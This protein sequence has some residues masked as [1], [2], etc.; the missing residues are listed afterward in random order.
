MNKLFAKL[1]VAVAVVSL[2]AVP[3][4]PSTV[5]A[6]GKPCDGGNNQLTLLPPW[7]KGLV[8]NDHGTPQ[9][10]TTENGL[11]DFIFRIILN[12]TEAMLYIVGY[13][14]LGMIIWGGFKYMLFGDN[15]GGV[16]AAKKT[17]QNAVIGLVISI[18]SITIVNFI[19]GAF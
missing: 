18:F 17:I 15:S 1:A 19:G 14:A 3:L 6:Q 16:E 13:I 2:L 7:Y 10:A 9:I 8:C 5:L 4:F 11:R 12:L